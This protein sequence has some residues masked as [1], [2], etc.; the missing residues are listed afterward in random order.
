MV[1]YRENYPHP[2]RAYKLFD[3]DSQKY[4][5]ARSVVFQEDKF[6]SREEC[7]KMFG[8]CSFDFNS[9]KDPGY[10]DDSESQARASRTVVPNNSS[11][12]NL[13]SSSPLLMATER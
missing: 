9:Y 3:L 5:F 12:T 11:L 10:E 7:S 6:L 4:I 2:T 1:G 8:K 13:Q